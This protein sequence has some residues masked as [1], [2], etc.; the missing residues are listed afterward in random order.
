MR[1]YS[2]GN[3]LTRGEMSSDL[4]DGSVNDI[5]WTCQP[6]INH[7]DIC[8]TKYYAFSDITEI[9]FF[10]GITLPKVLND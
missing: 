2:C 4:P 3:I 10:D 1:C 9:P 6:F 7:P 5:C 8:D